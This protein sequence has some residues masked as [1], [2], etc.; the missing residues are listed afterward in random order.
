MSA[1][2]LAFSQSVEQE[3]IKDSI[4]SKSGVKGISELVISA[5][6]KLEVNKLN[7]KNIDA[8]MTVNVVNK[9]VLQ[10]WDINNIEEAS[11]M[12]AGINPVKQY[13]GFQF[14]NIRGFD[15]FVILNDGV[16][17]ERHAITQSAPVANFANVER[18]E[19]LKG[20]SGDMFGHS[21]LGELSIL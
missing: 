21:A 13:A 2:V 5:Q 17:D 16:R 19:F 10:K 3:N 4:D 14:F 7:I 9:A 11:K 8:P 15:N 1:S 18:I 6:K 20:P 12:V